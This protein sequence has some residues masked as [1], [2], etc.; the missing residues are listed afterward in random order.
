MIV[1]ACRV[2][3]SAHPGALMATPLSDA[4]SGELSASVHTQVAT[5]RVLLI[6][7]NTQDV[8]L[9]CSALV[10]VRDRDLFA[11]QFAITSAKSLAEALACLAHQLF[12]V[13]LLDLSLPD[14]EDLEDTFTR[15]HRAAP[16]I[17]TIVM[18]GLGDELLGLKMLRDGAQD[19][20]MKSKVERYVLLKAIRYAIERQSAK[21]SH[22]ELRLKLIT[23][24][25]RERHRIAREL[26][27]QF[28]Q[29]IAAL[30]LGLKSL[31]ISCES[32]EQ[33]RYQFQVLQN[34]AN[35][36]AVDVHSLAL[37]LRPTALDDLGLEVAL[38]HHLERWSSRARISADFQ[39][40]GFKG[41][42]LASHLETT[43]YRITQEA[44]TNIVRH[45]RAKT[46][47][48]VLDVSDDR[49]NVI[50]EDDG[51]GFDT[52]AVMRNRKKEQQLGL[53]GMEER[54]ALVGGNLTIES[55]SGGGTSL[56]VRIPTQFT[57]TE[58]SHHEQVTNLDRGRSCF[59]ARRS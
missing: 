2:R 25:E 39:S 10:D 19:Y 56:Y 32:S 17:P 21:T 27:D 37:D 34:I 9:V 16:G 35:E 51:C 48:I 53:L 33:A 47:N 29:S 14:S 5:S 41:R 52:E 42:R 6:E 4:P 49:V 31:A 36:L 1:T 12:D 50:V 24:Q 23:A 43:I 54:V 13:I 3:P 59:I 46:V 11:P 45:A 55:V 58:D 38:L 20:M 22:A 44:L 18:T 30:M 26:H 15:I 28:G 57:P 40:H 8:Q 7:D